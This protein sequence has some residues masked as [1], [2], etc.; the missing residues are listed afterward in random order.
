MP[1]FKIFI[2]PASCELIDR[3]EQVGRVIIEVDKVIC[4]N[5]RREID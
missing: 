5:L 4:Q 1:D 3:Y 2:D